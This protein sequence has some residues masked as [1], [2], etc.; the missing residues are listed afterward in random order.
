MVIVMMKEKVK[1]AQS[2]ST[3]CDPMDCTVHGLLQARIL[4]WVAVPFSGASSKPRD[5][6]QASPI[7]GRFFTS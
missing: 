3:L 7:A 1:V 5:Q 6:T 2:S 4:E